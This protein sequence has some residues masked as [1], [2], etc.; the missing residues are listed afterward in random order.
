MLIIYLHKINKINKKIEKINTSPF[1]F[2]LKQYPIA[3]L[4]YF[5]VITIYVSFAFCFG[6]FID[7]Y[8]M[9]PFD[10]EKVNKES[11]QWLAIQIIIQLTFQC[12]FALFMGGMLQKIPSIFNGINGYNS[13]TS[14]GVFIRSPF[15]IN[16]ILWFLSKS[17]QGKLLI[18]F[19]RFDVN[20]K[21]LLPNK[22]T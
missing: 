7:G 1:S 16:I 9:P 4:D 3:L 22:K 18:L 11:S 17:L 2:P 12:F 20:A 15:I 5:C 21:N 10:E 14:L 13:N 6:L 8:L 19:S